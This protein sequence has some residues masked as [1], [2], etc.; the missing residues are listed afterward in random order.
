MSIASIW[1]NCFQ[2]NWLH[3]EDFG[4]GR[5]KRVLL[6]ELR[7]R[8]LREKRPGKSFLVRMER[9][10]SSEEIPH[11]SLPNMP[12]NVLDE[13]RDTLVW[14]ETAGTESPRGI[15]T[16]RR[17]LWDA[18]DLAPGRGEQKHGDPVCKKS[19]RPRQGHA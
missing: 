15:E 10:Q 19:G 11:D 18:P 14:Y 17:R 16:Y 12:R 5:F 9:S 6:S 4:N 8:G 1:S 7:V 2:G 13:K 3:M